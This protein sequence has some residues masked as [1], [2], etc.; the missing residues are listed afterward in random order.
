VTGCAW[1]VLTEPPAGPAWE[2]GGFP[3]GLEP[4]TLPPPGA[5]DLPS[6][7]R[8][9]SAYD[10]A[11]R[12]M[13]VIAGHGV[14]DGEVERCQSHE[15]LFWFRWITGHQVSFII[16]RLTRLLLDE[17]TVGRLPWAAVLRPL[18][19]YVRGYSA[20]LLYTG[21]CPIGIYH[22]VIRP[23]M[24]MRHS[25][26]SGRWAPDYWPVRDLLRSRRLPFARSPG[27]AD[28]LQAVE[29]VQLVHDAVAAKLV[30]DGTS[31]LRQ[32]TV[33]RQDMRV[34][35]LI[36]DNYFMTLR[37][38]VSRRDV[39][40]QLLRR[41]VAIARDV[42]V[43]D[44]HPGAGAVAEEPWESPRTADLVAC[45]CGLTG[46]L[47]QV[48]SCAAELAD[49]RTGERLRSDDRCSVSVAGG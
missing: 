35:H 4:L 7:E 44:L 45:E 6:P 16:W 48:A 38:P 32:S 20:M 25:S 9:P 5:P 46:I 13:H 8:N 22:D 24:R 39:V 33:R 21:S 40:A 49:G 15:V 36:Y 10:E 41:L 34:L 12:R 26:F 19:H 11:C 17:V 31:L 3:Y 47:A 37:A 42:A 23:S 2:F 18:S 43:N 27:S 30:P 14:D 1:P 28:L 29:L